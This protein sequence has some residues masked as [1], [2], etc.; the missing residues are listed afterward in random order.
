MDLAEPSAAEQ[1]VVLGSNF[2]SLHFI[3]QTTERNLKYCFFSVGIDPNMIESN[4]FK[5]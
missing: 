4:K 2:Y 5:S 3:Q 1:Y